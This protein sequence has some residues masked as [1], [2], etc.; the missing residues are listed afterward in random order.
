MI[1]PD[2]PWLMHFTHMDNLPG[3]A[4]AGLLADNQRQRDVRECGQPSIKERRRRRGVPVPPGGV[5]ADYAPFYFAP[6]S[7]MLRS[8]VGGRV[9]QYDS[10]QT[11]LIYLVTRLSRVIDAGLAW[12]ATDRNAVLHTARFAVEAV[13]LADHI[14]WEIM[15]VRFWGNTPED[16]SRRERRMAE[17]LVHGTVPW[18]VFSHLVVC[19]S[20][21]V[22]QVRDRLA[23]AGATLRVIVK[24]D[25][26]FEVPSGCSCQ[27]AWDG[28]GGETDDR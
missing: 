2:D 9:R 8:I 28:E 16:G 18:P 1:G 25:W 22:G 27:G 3:I 23:E 6:R 11:H 19:C 4:H 17:L 26:Y 10:D 15:N 13:E 5:V 7:P 14:D 20:Q 21:R 12:V 24:P